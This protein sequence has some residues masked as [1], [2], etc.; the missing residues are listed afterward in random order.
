MLERFD[1]IP[2]SY[3]VEMNDSENAYN[4]SFCPVENNLQ[5]K[6]LTLLGLTVHGN[7]LY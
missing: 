4:L 1:G 3:I 5:S 7:G 2:I 6:R